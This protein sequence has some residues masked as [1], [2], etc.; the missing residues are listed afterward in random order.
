MLRKQSSPESNS[1]PDLHLNSNCNDY[2]TDAQLDRVGSEL[3][4]AQPQVTRVATKL[5]PERALSGQDENSP[6]N[7]EIGPEKA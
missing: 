4:W 1:K 5:S 2:H 6:K 3:E 7:R